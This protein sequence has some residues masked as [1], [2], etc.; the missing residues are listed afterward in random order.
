M[1][2][3]TIKR[4]QKLRIIRYAGSDAIMIYCTYGKVDNTVDHKTAGAVHAAMHELL[5]QPCRGISASFNGVNL[6]LDL[7]DN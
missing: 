2:H 4:S 7:L 5:K 3:N 6:Q 1:K